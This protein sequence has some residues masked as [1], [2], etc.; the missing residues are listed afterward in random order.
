MFQIIKNNKKTLALA[1]STLALAVIAVVT[2]WRL[3]QFGEQPVAPT[4]PEKVPA[5]SQ[6]CKVTFSLVPT[7]PV[8]STCCKQPLTVC[9]NSIQCGTDG[10]CH[11]G[12]CIKRTYNE[13]TNTCPAATT[14]QG[15]GSGGEGDGGGTSG[16]G[17]GGTTT[18]PAQPTVTAS[19]RATATASPAPTATASPTATSQPGG[20]SKSP[21]VPTGCNDAKPGS[22]PTITKATPGT[23]SVALTW[24]KATDPVTHYYVVYGTSPGKEQF[25]SP[26]IGN[27]DTTTYTVRNLSG[28]TTYYF[29]IAAVNGCMP[30]NYSNELSGKPTGSAVSGPA[31]GFKAVGPTP[32]ATAQAQLPQAGTSWPLTLAIGA[33]ALLLLLGLVLA[34]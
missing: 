28:G 29:R 32:T 31:A 15:G 12:Y 6:A 2:A 1:G 17:S 25:G 13:A 20:G 7:C 26:N 8:N 24:T 5:V 19:P 22:A 4:A 18:S 9:D 30:G 16:G 14:P 23:N 10:A 21:A 34:F 11:L 33:G 3:S 27:K